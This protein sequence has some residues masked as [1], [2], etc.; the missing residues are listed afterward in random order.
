MRRFLLSNRQGAQLATSVYR[1]LVHGRRLKQ[2][3]NLHDFRP[4]P[5]QD[6]RNLMEWCLLVSRR[7]NKTMEA[8]RSERGPLGGVFENPRVSGKEY[9]LIVGF[10]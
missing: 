9:P 4:S 8:R 7:Q 2:S 1:D 10:P 5:Y 3:N 6:G